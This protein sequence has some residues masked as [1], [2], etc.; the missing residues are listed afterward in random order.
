MLQIGQLAARIQDPQILNL[1]NRENKNDGFYKYD[2]FKDNYFILNGVIQVPQTNFKFFILNETILEPFE[3]FHGEFIMDGSEL[4][5]HTINIIQ[6]ETIDVTLRYINKDTSGVDSRTYKIIIT[7]F[8]RK[9]IV[10]DIKKD[11]FFQNSQYKLGHITFEFWGVPDYQFKLNLLPIQ[12]MQYRGMEYSKIL[13]DICKKIG[14]EYCE[15]DSNDIEKPVNYVLKNDNFIFPSSIPFLQ[16]LQK[17]LVN[18]WYN[19]QNT[20]LYQLPI[21]FI[22]NGKM[23]YKRLY[24]ETVVNNQKD[25]YIGDFWDNYMN[26]DSNSEDN[27]KAWFSVKNEKYVFPKFLYYCNQRNQI[28]GQISK[29]NLNHIF[30][31][32]DTEDIPLK[33][34][35]LWQMNRQG[36]ENLKDIFEKKDYLFEKKYQEFDQLYLEDEYILENRI[37]KKYQSALTNLHYNSD[38]I[39]VYGHNFTDPGLF[40]LRI[41]D[42][43]KLHLDDTISTSYKDVY[44]DTIIA[45]IFS[46]E[47]FIYPQQGFFGINFKF[48]F[49]GRFTKYQEDVGY[50]F[51]K[52]VE[53][54]PYEDV[55]FKKYV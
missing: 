2:V 37:A 42:M 33:H 50:D 21:L 18:T 30:N 49:N 25:I 45:T 3:T 23:I 19:L 7:R 43:V 20:E 24:N 32:I 48:Q 54:H 1:P 36:P 52:Y 41:S 40:N 14:I 22:N 9:D 31:N 35:Y 4:A 5:E 29:N 34:K 16:V 44:K 53:K 51:P 11:D 15:T 6:P 39:M 55:E 10:R 38:M 8:V 46:R 13:I 47:I 26:Y 28:Y 17:I 27:T 12:Q